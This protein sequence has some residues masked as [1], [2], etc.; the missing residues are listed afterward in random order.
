MADDFEN[1]WQ[2]SSC[3]SSSLCCRHSCHVVPCP[4]SWLPGFIFFCCFLPLCAVA[5]LVLWFPV[6]FRVL[7]L[8][9]LSIYYSQ[10][11]LSL[12]SR[13]FSSSSSCHFFDFFCCRFSILIVG[14]S[15]QLKC[16]ISPQRENI[17][18]PGASVQNAILP[19]S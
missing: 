6:R 15:F 9:I 18:E 7:R 16:S 17:N 2:V 19:E 12:T 3:A 11:I 8:S 14:D 1:F 5:L 10:C 13:H 4:L